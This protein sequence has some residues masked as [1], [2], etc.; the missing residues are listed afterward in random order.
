LEQE[1]VDGATVAKLIQQGLGAPT[2]HEKTPEK[3]P[4]AVDPERD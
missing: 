3:K 4:D 1:T 2:I